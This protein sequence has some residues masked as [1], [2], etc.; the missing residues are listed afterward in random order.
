MP[1]SIAVTVGIAVATR[2][3]TAETLITGARVAA[4]RQQYQ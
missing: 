4:R 1:G 3:D 2:H